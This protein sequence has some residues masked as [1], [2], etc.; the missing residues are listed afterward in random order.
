MRREALQELGDRDQPVALSPE[1]FEEIGQAVV[2]AVGLPVGVEV[3]ENDASAQALGATVAELE[4]AGGDLFTAAVDTRRTIRHP[5]P[6]VQILR[7]ADS[8]RPGDVAI[9]GL[10][11]PRADLS[12]VLAVRGTPDGG[13][14]LSDEGAEA[15]LRPPQLADQELARDGGQRLLTVIRRVRRQVGV[16]CIRMNCPVRNIVARTL[17]AR[18]L[19]RIS[20]ATFA[21]LPPSN[22]NAISRVNK[23]PRL[24]SSEA[25]REF[26]CER[27]CAGLSTG[28]GGSG[29]CVPW[30]DSDETGVAAGGTPRGVSDAA[31]GDGATGACEENIGPPRTVATA[32]RSGAHPP[33]IPHAASAK[34]RAVAPRNEGTQ[35]QGRSSPRGVALSRRSRR[36]WAAAASQEIHRSCSR[37]RRLRGLLSISNRMR[38][39]AVRDAMPKSQTMAHGSQQNAREPTKR[40][41]LQRILSPHCRQRRPAS[42]SAIR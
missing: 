37:H 35:N 8:L 42:L 5:I 4:D 2:R 10:C 20:P 12:V 27:A 34:T 15:L 14:S 7:R 40:A 38:L 6:G 25:P 24:I 19:S 39:Q 23:S 3:H 41:E 22:V 29:A 28:A 17:A 11:G 26:K 18:R 31:A 1:G 30:G 33:E 36:R 32:P 13:Q 16:R 9:A 21:S